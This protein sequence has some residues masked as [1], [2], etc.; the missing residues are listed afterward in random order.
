MARFQPPLVLTSAQPS[1][2]R[3]LRA[4][5]G[6][7][8][9]SAIAIAATAAIARHRHPPASQRPVP[10]AGQRPLLGASLATATGAGRAE[11]PAMPAKAPRNGAQR[12]AWGRTSA[13]TPSMSAPATS[14]RAG[15]RSRTASQNA[16]SVRSAARGSVITS[17]A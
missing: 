6:N 2:T 7:T 13:A 5:H 10:P 1:M 11:P 17:A 12:S 8:G 16:A 9:S 15:R 14:P 3:Q 4:V